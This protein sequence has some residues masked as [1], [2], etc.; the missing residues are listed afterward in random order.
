MN[1]DIINNG[2]ATIG[3][4]LGSTRIKAIMADEFG[5]VLAGGAYDW[6][7]QYENGVWTYSLDMVKKGVQGAYKALKEDISTKYGITLTTPAA[8]GISGMMHGYLVFDS[9]DNQLCEFRTWR[10]NIT[11]KAAAELTKLFNFNIPLRWSIAH[12]YHAILEKEEHVSK[13][14]FMTTVAGYVHYMLSGEKAL[15]IGEASGVFPIDINTKNY[16]E[17]MLNSF[18]ELIKPY[19]FEWKIREILPKVLVAGENAGILT[20]AGAKWLDPEGDLKAGVKLAPPEGDAGS[21]MVATN[22]IAKRTGNVSAGTSA[23]AMVVL[24]KA[25]SKVYT[26]LDMV[27]T[28]TGDLVAMAH[29][30][31]CTTDLNSW[32]ALF[33]ETLKTFGIEASKGE[34]FEK[35]FKKSLEGDADCGNLV[36]YCFHSGEHGVGLESGCPMMIHPTGSGFNLANLMRSHIYTSF[37]AMKLGMDILTKEE[38]VKV[39][40]YLA[41]GGI[42]KTEGVAIKYLSA[43]MGAPAALME[44]AGEG[45]PW[46]MALL[47]AYMLKKEEENIS[48]DDYLNKYIFATAK[49]IEVKA[50][51][52]E[53]EGYEKFMDNFKKGLTAEKAAV[54]AFA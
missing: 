17:T 4:E 22:C 24:E 19:G 33:E 49:V 10:N 18:E 16:D 14:D 28:P 27:T 36:S 31:N 45:G 12:L 3:I 40:R 47:A 1:T 7:N 30:N 13:I 44:T 2:K 54:E 15:G 6:E 46:G 42:F 8:L 37:A 52:K 41:Q 5:K 53:V 26:Q 9:E 43:A 29:A 23:F 51:P 39:D 25:L 38:G 35:L 21:G 48:L 32:I 11:G 20:E 34:I 50:E